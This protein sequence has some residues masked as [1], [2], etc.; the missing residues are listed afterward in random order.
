[1]RC[2]KLQSQ[3]IMASGILSRVMQGILQD[4]KTTV[5]FNS[6]QIRNISQVATNV[7]E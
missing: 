4:M 1:M 3:N 7:M 5:F 2:N 6:G